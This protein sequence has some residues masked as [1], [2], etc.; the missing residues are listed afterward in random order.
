MSDIFPLDLSDGCKSL[1]NNE[2]RPPLLNGIKTRRTNFS[3]SKSL[4]FGYNDN[5]TLPRSFNSFSTAILFKDSRGLP[6]V[7]PLKSSTQSYPGLEDD[8]LNF[9]KCYKCYDLI[10]TSAKLVVI[11]TE[12]VLKK[13]FF[14]MVETGVRSCPLWDSQSQTFVGMLTITDFIRILQ[15][16]YKGSLIEMEIFEEQR[17][18]DWKGLTEHS[19]DLIYVSPDA[20]LY[21]AVSLLIENK[22][23]R[24]P[25]IDPS[26]G[27][28]LYILNQKPLLRFLFDQ[29]P[30]L[31]SFNHLSISIAEAGV[32]TFDNIEVASEDTTIIEAVNKF[33]K[34][35]ISAL[36]IVD[37]NS[38][39]VGIYS[40]FDVINLAATKTY[41]DLEVTLK[42]ATEHK[43][44]HGDGVHSC[45]GDEPVLA[46]M[47]KLVKAE[48]NRLVVV[49]AEEKVV[50]IV[51]VSDIINHLVVKHTSTSRTPT[52]TIRPARV[53][54]RREDSIGEEVELE[55]E[56]SDSLT[57]RFSISCSPPHWFNV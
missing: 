16:N 53:R 13:A 28:V 18:M 2:R 27:N 33:V 14:A 25:I 55:E 54:Q 24:L 12:L 31:D 29:V 45:R 57:S 20:S 1:P 9:F 42:E 32:G 39:L 47:E 30:H 38:R 7:Q 41:T 4:S 34:E 10:P 8:I 43:L 23:H 40:K 46:V 22:I 35:G 56:E 37:E 36:P 21:E 51:T 26:N 11:D 5:R 44:T 15:K 6:V 17:L 48:V 49:D 3:Y 19:K 52:R 50:G